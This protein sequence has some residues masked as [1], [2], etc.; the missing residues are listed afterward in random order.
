MPKSSKRQ[1]SDALFGSSEEVGDAFLEIL[2]AARSDTETCCSEPSTQIM[3][4]R[5]SEGLETVQNFCS[6][7]ERSTR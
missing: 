3:G 1:F 5:I 7:L 2:L 6:D 4:F